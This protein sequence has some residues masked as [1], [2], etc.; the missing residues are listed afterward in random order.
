MSEQ[1]SRSLK[2]KL[3]GLFQ[4][5]PHEVA[6]VIIGQLM[7]LCLFTGYFMLRPVRDTMGITGGVHNLQWLFTATFVSTLIV[8]PIFG[9]MASVI[10]RR[11]LMPWLYSVCAIIFVGFAAIFYNDPENVSAARCFYVWLSV[12]NLAAVSLAWSVLADIMV[13]SQAKRIFALIASGA[14]A[15]GLLGPLTGTVLVGFAGNEGLLI[16]FAILI[17]MSASCGFWLHRWRDRHPI[18]EE[19][20]QS[21]DKKQ[22]HKSIGGNPFAGAIETFK[23]PYLISI[24]IFVLL[25]A[26]VSTFLYFEQARLVADLFPDKTRQTQVF[27]IIDMI[28][29]GSTLFIQIFLTGW[30]AK[31][32]GVGILLVAIPCVMVVGF[33]ALAIAPLFFVFVAVMVARRVGQYALGRP[34]REMLYTVLPTEQ[35]YKAKNFV[36]TVVYRGGDALSGWLKRIIDMVG[37]NPAVAMFIGAGIATSWAVCGFFLGRKQADLEDSPYVHKAEKT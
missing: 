14:S 31:R 25:M 32:F 17:L 35:K 5:E 2:Q 22:Q 28:V 27:G 19:K 11:T 9:W 36:D 7:F 24:S 34:G 33:A 4:V 18:E 1:T 13:V 20:D 15:G 26:S 8:L 16:V 21:T 12:F 29:Q 10:T 23:S 37:E 30:I 6:A 3:S